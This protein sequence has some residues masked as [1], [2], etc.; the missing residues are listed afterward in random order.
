[1]ILRPLIIPRAPTSSNGHAKP[2]SQIFLQTEKRID[3]PFAIIFQAEHSALAGHIAQALSPHVFGK[4]PREVIE[5]ISQHD[6]GWNSS[7]QSQMAAR[8]H[9]TPRPFPELSTEESLPS[10]YESV[11]HA[12]KLGA[13]AYVTVSRHF[14]TLATGD[15]S[16]AEF[17]RTETKRRAEVER[18]LD[19]TASDLDRWTGAIGFCDLVSL[20][21]SC[22]CQDSV[23]FPIAHPADPAAVHAPKTIL[24]WEEGSPSFSPPILQPDTNLSLDVRTYAGR[25]AELTPLRLA[26]NFHN[27]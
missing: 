9:Q 2:A 19:Y 5:A 6:F 4:L 18:A 16:R 8:G 10:W 11:A 21:L 14:K 25:K 24:S 26:W 1:M 17:V 12:R 20:Y 27:G 15:E 22:G 23:E 13:L 7:D 3:L